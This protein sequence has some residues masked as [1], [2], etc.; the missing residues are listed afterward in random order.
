MTAQKTKVRN[1]FLLSKSDFD[2]LQ[3]LVDSPRY[4]ATHANA[5]TALK[6]QLASSEVVAHASVPHDVVTMRSSIVVRDAESTETEQ[7]TLVYPDEADIENARVSVLAPLGLAL[8][9]TR[10]GETVT[11]DTPLGTRHVTI[12]S[13]AYQPEAA[14]DLYL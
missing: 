9:C 13:I 11:F 10:V 7:F 2:R 1:K 8:L 6:G 3:A 12:E 5:L 4:R 14:G